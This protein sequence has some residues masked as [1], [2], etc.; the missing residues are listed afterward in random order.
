MVS[1]IGVA[2][3]GLPKGSDSPLRQPVFAVG[4]ALVI[5]QRQRGGLAFEQLYQLA[6]GAPQLLGCVTQVPIVCSQGIQRSGQQ[7]WEIFVLVGHD[8]AAALATR[9]P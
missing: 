8:D 6:G 3:N 5:Q 2:V 7:R 1:R 9:T 4:F